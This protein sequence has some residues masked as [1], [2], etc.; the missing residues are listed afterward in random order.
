[1]RGAPL[2]LRPLVQ[3]SPGVTAGA[4][5]C[6]VWAVAWVVVGAIWFPAWAGLYVLGWM[7]LCLAPLLVG[8]GSLLWLGGA[9]LRLEADGL[10]FGRDRAEG[11]VSAAARLAHVAPW[12]AVS[13]VRVVSGLAATNE[14]RAVA[15]PVRG[16]RQPSVF[17]GY[18]PVRWRRAHLALRVDP[19]RLRLPRVRSPRRAADRPVLVSSVWVLPIRRPDRVRAWLAER[20]I[21][22]TETATAVQ[23]EPRRSMA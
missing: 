15:R 23:P 14:M 11:S 1:M 13:E 4:V 19:S 9:D 5:L 20:G 21:V 6:V 2:S 3:R 10:R 12:S 16:I 22:V 7:V 8:L 17:L 18:Y